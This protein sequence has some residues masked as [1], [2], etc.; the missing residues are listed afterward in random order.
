MNEVFQ[1][2]N[3]DPISMR[4]DQ[5]LRAM[6]PS[7]LGPWAREN[8]MHHTDKIIATDPEILVGGGKIIDCYKMGNVNPCPW[9][10]VKKQIQYVLY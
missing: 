5:E 2:I 3:K 7:C 6:R 8:A 1:L 4:E 9:T 10:L